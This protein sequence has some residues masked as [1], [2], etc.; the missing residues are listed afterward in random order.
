VRGRDRVRRDRRV[1]T[2][3]RHLQR[4]GT[5]DEQHVVEASKRRAERAAD[6]RRAKAGAIDVEVGAQRAVFARHHVADGAVGVEL[7]PFDGG[8]HVAHAERSCVFAEQRGKAPGVEVVGVVERAH[9]VGVTR[10]LRC[11]RC[12]GDALLHRRGL[13]ERD[14]RPC[15]AEQPVRQQLGPARP[16]AGHAE[17]M[18]VVVE[19]GRAVRPHPV[20]ELDA[21]LEGRAAFTQETRL[22]DADRRER[23]SDRRKGS[24]ADADDADLAGFDQRDAHALAERAGQKGR[25]QP[26]RGA[27]ADDEHA[28][29]GFHG[30][31]PELL[32]ATGG[33]AHGP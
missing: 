17:R 7:D 5:V 18:K 23:S 19:P 6:Q 1:G 25:G 33:A 2:F 9:E 14:L 15:R 22:V 29:D 32:Q 28:L 20:D 27:A 12:V 16:L 11:V 3:V 8:D 21:L 31:F 24:F 26:P 13:R 10:A 4:D 30:A